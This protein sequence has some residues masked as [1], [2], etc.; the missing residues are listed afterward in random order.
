MPTTATIVTSA[1]RA[2]EFPYRA[3]MKSEIV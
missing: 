3:A 1:E 2:S